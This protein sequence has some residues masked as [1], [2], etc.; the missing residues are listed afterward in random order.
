MRLAIVVCAAAYL[1]RSYRRHASGGSHGWGGARRQRRCRR[2]DLGKK[3]V[4]AVRHPQIMSRHGIQQSACAPACPAAT[5]R[6][7]PKPSPACL[8]NLWVACALRHN[9]HRLLLSRSMVKMFKCGSFFL[10]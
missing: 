5:P 10:L 8:S 1:P 9:H 2:P 4:M 3:R 7:A 6:S